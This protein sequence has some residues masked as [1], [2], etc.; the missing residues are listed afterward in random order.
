MATTLN[1]V[2]VTLYGHADNDPPGSD[3]TSLGGHAGGTG[4]FDDP[5]TAA[6]NS[7]GL[8]GQF[9]YG[10]KF[11][12]PEL[13]K[14]FVIGD[15][16][17]NTSGGANH[18]DL[19]VQS[20]SNTPAS[21]SN[22]AENALTGNYQIILNPPANQPVNGTPLITA[23]NDLNSV[24]GDHDTGT[25]PA[26]AAPEPAPAQPV[27]TQ[28]V[29]D[30]TNRANSDS[31]TASQSSGHGW[32]GRDHSGHWGHHGHHDDGGAADNWSFHHWSHHG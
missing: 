24:V 15:Y 19:W 26:A 14:Y 18:V 30:T 23:A 9:A 29:A 3:T 10:T 11:Y 13:Q 7:A 28:P 2:Y 25:T 20:Q 12:V 27:V 6:A 21:Q 17:A 32:S 4:T 5:V 16:M 8:S 31:G 22:A 1:N